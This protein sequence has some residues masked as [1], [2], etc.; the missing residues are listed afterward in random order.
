MSE[1]YLRKQHGELDWIRQA[2][3]VWTIPAKLD[4]DAPEPTATEP[5]RLQ[6]V[7]KQWVEGQAGFFERAWRRD[8]RKA[9]VI[10]I[11]GYGFFCV[12]LALA[13][14]KVVW[15]SEDPVII[16]M[17]LTLVISVLLSVY[18][19]VLGLTEHANQYA[20]LKQIFDRGAERL[21]HLLKD[22]K[23]T[24]SQE[25]V[26]EMG[27]EALIENG[28]WLL[29]HRASAGG[30]SAS[31]GSI[32]VAHETVRNPTHAA[33]YDQRRKDYMMSTRTFRVFVSSTFA[34][35]VAERNALQHRV[36]PELAKICEKAG[37]RFQAIDLR[38]G[39]PDEAGLDQR[40]SRI[41]LQ[42]L[43]RCQTTSPRPNF[44][45]LLANRYG[46]RPLPEEIE[47]EEF[48]F[49]EA[50]AA[51]LK[52]PNAF[53]LRQW[54]WLDGNAVPA[55]HYLR[56]REKEGEGDKDFTQF[57]VWSEQV[58][59]PLREL[60]VTCVA[61]IPFSDEPRIKYE[62]SLTEREILA[63]ALN[64][65]VT[66]AHEHVFAYV[67]EI[68][69]LDA[70]ESAT[71]ADYAH[72]R[73]FLDFVDDQPSPQG[74]HRRDLVARQRQRDLQAKL[75]MSLGSEH[76]RRFSAT[77]TGIGVSQDHI[78]RLCDAVLSDLRGVIEAEIAKFTAGDSLDAEIAAHKQF[79]ELRGGKERF[80]GREVLLSR[81]IAYLEADEPNRPLVIF[82]PA[83]TGKSAIVAR[84]AEDARERLPQAV[85][86]ERFIG[87]TP[88][89][90][91]ARS[92]LQ[93][94]C[95]EL[96][97]QFQSDAAV[98]LEYRELVTAFRERLAWAT[99]E[100]P[101]IIFLDAVDQLSET[102]NAKSLVWLPRQLPP[103]VRLVVSVLDDPLAAPSDTG[104]KAPTNADPLAII[105]RRTKPEDLLPIED[106]P[107]DDA[108]TLLDYW[109]LADKRT[110]SAA[111]KNLV[112]GAFEGCPRPLFLKLVA[113]EAKQWRS[114]NHSAK[115]PKAD[116]PEAMLGAII[117]L[118]FDRL[119]E[120]SHH[121][122][123]LVER[124]IGYLV[125]A[126]NGLTEDELIGLLSTDKEFFGEFQRRAESVNQ[127]LPPGI[128]SLPVAVWVRLYSD[129]QP[130]LT[131]RR[132]DG[133]TLLAFY[134]R[135]LELVARGRFL[136]TPEI[137]G[138]R[139]KHIANYFTP[140]EP[141]GFF[142]LTLDEQRAWAKKLPPEPRPVNIRMVMELPHQLLEVAKVLGKDDAKSPHWDA[143]A[144]LLLNIHFLEA[145]A[146]AK[147]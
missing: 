139:H 94:L 14:F 110:L 111:Q 25:I 95:E 2:L 93:S 36:F 147:P 135:S 60:F 35:L 83:G 34:D 50:K 99:A 131:T 96:G 127:P 133:T 49:I 47:A 72:L 51:E 129:L 45:I 31:V 109:L 55:V 84:M 86:L 18:S 118:L 1:I 53:L 46:W 30:S 124:A 100:R 144:D 33:T 23:M 125:A 65:N 58:E 107:R 12:G 69:T 102:D 11:F 92:L 121:G 117:N 59:V 16:F 145:K 140:A 142:R 66:D 114:D 64:P 120:K 24:E 62:R 113:E 7:L 141:F 119:S 54:Y 44:I 10:G 88:P 38:W 101:V 63:G 80:K 43:E 56:R 32:P 146:E 9:R 90:V 20:R 13:F 132:A 28:D 21:R 27:Q 82:G 115:V 41:C 81:V 97:R 79:G 42:E 3:R 134:H 130:Y 123:L 116:S 138:Q 5:D 112:L 103:H 76:V 40:T 85:I 48:K 15:P 39:I 73:P 37:C 68:S 89:S 26:D 4:L 17:S 137:A 106:Y 71:A 29:F 126:K 143:V 105:R 87:A 61:A 52:L 108:Q 74:E 8:H 77:W 75:T 122:S 136:A 57:K 98:P 128:D 70:L 6:I 22:G 78:S 67:R 91:D 19:Q 104:G